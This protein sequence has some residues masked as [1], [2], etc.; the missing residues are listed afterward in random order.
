MTPLESVR[1]AVYQQYKLDPEKIPAHVAIVMD[2][3]GRWAKKRFLPRIMGHRSG[4]ESLRTTIKTCV[5]FGISYLTVYVF[6]TENWKRPATEVSFL[7]GFLKQLV[8]QELPELKS[9]GV[10]I[11]FLGELS[12]L[13]DDLQ[14]NIRI[15]QDE[16]AH[17]TILTLNMMVNYGSR[18]E[19]LHA[20]KAMVR[21]AKNGTLD[22]ASVTESVFSSYLYTKTIPDPDILIRTGGDIR[23]SNYLLWQI[24]YSELFFLDSLWPDFNRDTLIKVLQEFQNRERRFGALIEEPEA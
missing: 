17:N 16:T 9:Q 11:Q 6:S 10:K 14:N 18:N 19:I 2:G 23:I 15:A 1:L 24:A 22:E 3:N 12:A 13:A 21:D 8:L 5:E 20:C 7:M 4:A